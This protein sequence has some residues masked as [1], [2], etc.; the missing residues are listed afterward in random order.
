MLLLVGGGGGQILFIKTNHLIWDHRRVIDLICFTHKLIS[1]DTIEIHLS[2]NQCEYRDGWTRDQVCVCVW[3]C[4][5][6]VLVGG[7]ILSPW[8]VPRYNT[9]VDILSISKKNKEIQ[10]SINLFKVQRK[11]TTSVHMVAHTSFRSPWWC[12]EKQGIVNFS[13]HCFCLFTH[14]L[15]ISIIFFIRTHA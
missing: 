5:W 3:V 10:V 1:L 4:L 8:R 11:L 13:S 15:Y 2:I 9:S 6:D 14:A 12:T 7:Q